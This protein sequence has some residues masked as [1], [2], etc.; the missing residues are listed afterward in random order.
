MNPFVYGKS[1][2][3]KSF[4]IRIG[5]LTLPNPKIFRGGHNVPPPR[6][7]IHQNRP[8][9]IGLTYLVR[10]SLGRVIS[11]VLDEANVHYWTSGGSTLGIVRCAKGFDQNM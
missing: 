9:Q 3:G 7:L 1:P 4:P 10:Y 8:G 5:T 6:S 11:A 2:L